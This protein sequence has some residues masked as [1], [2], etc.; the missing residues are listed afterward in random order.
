[1]ISDNLTKDERIEKEIRRLNGIYKS[2]S[3]KEKAVIDGLIK[4]AAYMRI[5]LEEMEEDLK[6]NGFTDEFT[7]SPNTPSYERQR[8]LAGIYNTLNK[9]YQ[10]IMKQLTEFVDHKP[11]EQKEKNDG[12]EDFVGDR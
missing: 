2:L 12:F 9:N 4:R 7:Q 3:K 5:A 8:P 10:T 6:V 11:S 1:M